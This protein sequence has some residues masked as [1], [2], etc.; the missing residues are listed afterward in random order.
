M[1]WAGF[2]LAVAAVL[3]LCG[4]APAQE[5]QAP[6]DGSKVSPQAA[7]Q[8]ARDAAAELRVTRV[9]G[10][11]QLTR[12]QA[13]QLAP[14]LEQAQARLRE[15]DAQE[16]AALARLKAAA[17]EARRQALAGGQPSAASEQQYLSVSREWQARRERARADQ[18]ALIR[19]RLMRILTPQ[20]LA[21]LSAAVQ[22]AALQS[23]SAQAMAEFTTGARGGG[24]INA[25][26]RALD[27]VRET[28][29]GE[30]QRVRER[31]AA[32]L[33]GGGPPGPPRPGPGGPRGA[34]GGGPGGPGGPPRPGGPPGGPGL[35]LNNPAVQAQLQQTLAFL[36]QVRGM[37]AEQ[38][39]QAR[40]GLGLELWQRTNQA[41]AMGTRDPEEMIRRL[42][43]DLLDPVA[44]KV[45]RRMAG[46]GGE[47]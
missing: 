20:Q 26:T 9:L 2:S 22:A 32:G 41:R 40:A 25:T 45:A 15:A 1:N 8:D 31:M 34:P 11:L 10:F 7:A 4:G 47:R 30:W 23:Q 14:V 35:N 37:S 33:A 12:S 3:S 6:P 18:A 46:Q 16:S 21:N 17:D 27:R 42:V 39:T 29:Q 13:A 43:E 24:P 38:Y 28:P 19:S 44:P 36:E 5:V